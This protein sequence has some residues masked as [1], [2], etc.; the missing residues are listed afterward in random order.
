MLPLCFRPDK[1]SLC[2][3][4][5]APSNSGIIQLK[6]TAQIADVTVKLCDHEMD[7]A[8][9]HLK[10]FTSFLFLSRIQSKSSVI[11]LLYSACRSVHPSL[12]VDTLT[13]ESG[14]PA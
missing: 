7:F 11:T 8:S 10:G 14:C 1:S 5:T 12:D 2:F 6:I 4:L 13:P 3:C 9:V